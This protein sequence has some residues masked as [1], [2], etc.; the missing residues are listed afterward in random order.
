MDTATPVA[1]G[2]KFRPSFTLQQVRDLPPDVRA[3][4]VA[5]MN[6]QAAQEG[7]VARDFLTMVMR[8][9]AG[10]QPPLSS[11]GLLRELPPNVRQMIMDSQAVSMAEFF[12]SWA[13]SIEHNAREDKKAHLRAMRQKETLNR[14]EVLK[15]QL[16]HLTAGLERA[17][18]L[19]KIPADQI[20]KIRAKIQEARELLGAGVASETLAT[21]RADR[22][23]PQLELPPPATNLC[24]SRPR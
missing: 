3:V 12:K 8:G 20:P 14:P 7:T 2:T 13:E 18:N 23:P 11:L 22:Q 5:I 15:R 16:R 4:A 6:G 21:R 19:G 24:L 17:I 1:A 10:S 9:N